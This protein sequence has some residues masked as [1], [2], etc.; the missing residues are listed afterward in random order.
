[1]PVHQTVPILRRNR[2][3]P[4]LVSLTQNVGGA[5]GRETLREDAIMAAMVKVVFLE[6]ARRARARAVRY[7]EMTAAINAP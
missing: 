2:G 5:N 7:R 6:Q 4:T 1:M 3:T